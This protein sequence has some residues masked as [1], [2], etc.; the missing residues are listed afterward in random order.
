M[1]SL[2]SG[3]RICLMNEHFYR[4]ISTLQNKTLRC[5]SKDS[6]TS[7]R[8]EPLDVMGCIDIVFFIGVDHFVHTF[9]IARDIQQSI[10]P[11]WDFLLAHEIQVK[12]RYFKI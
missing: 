3:A 2:D 1:H 9:R 7:M 12:Q 4:S 10:I 5:V 8:G 11:G 6:I